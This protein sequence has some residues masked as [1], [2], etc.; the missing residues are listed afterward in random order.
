MKNNMGATH[1]SV[2]TGLLKRRL[3]FVGIQPG[4]KSIKPFDLWN[5]LDPVS[6]IPA[7]STRKGDSF[8]EL[9]LFV[10]NAFS[11]RFKPGDI[12]RP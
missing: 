2:L 9:G 8:R 4:Y 5:A 10:P 12:Y 6:E 11:G 3:Q 7:G 1:C